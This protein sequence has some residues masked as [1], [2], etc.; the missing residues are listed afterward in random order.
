MHYIIKLN[1]LDTNFEIM[2]TGG[3]IQ[4]WWEIPMDFF[5]RFVFSLIK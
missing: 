4:E 5:Y 1:Y 2:S 3:Q